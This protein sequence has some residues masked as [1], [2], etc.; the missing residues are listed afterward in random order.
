MTYRILVADDDADN[1]VIAGETL[2]IAGYEVLEAA[3]G[4]QAL[5]VSLRE[6]PDLILLDMSMPGLTGWEV[7]KRLRGS[8]DL[9]RTK[10]LA[11][12]AHALRGDELK[13]KVA[14][15]DGYIAK[16]CTSRELIQQLRPY[17]G[18]EDAGRAGG[19]P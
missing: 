2:R 17:L 11:F 6:K 1:R 15:C 9:S 10:I 7:A 19:M 14:G 3:S 16:P 12:T 18:G 5:E 4:D 8:A 13:A